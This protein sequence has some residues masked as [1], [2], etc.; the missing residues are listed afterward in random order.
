VEIASTMI[1]LKNCP[2]N[3]VLHQLI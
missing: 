2:L 1:S 3:S